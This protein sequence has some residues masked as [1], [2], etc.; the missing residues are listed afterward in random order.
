MSKVAAESRTEN[1][2]SN[3]LVFDTLAMS[4]RLRSVGVPEEQANEQ[5]EI[6]AEVFKHN[7]ATQADVQNIRKDITLIKREIADVRAELKK[8]IADVRKEIADLRKELKKD[9]ELLRLEFKKDMYKMKS[10]II[11]WVAG[12]LLAQAAVIGA[13]QKLF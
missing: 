2:K 4:K 5:V 7:M 6:I 11:L 8:D 10:S 9:I 3:G 1:N 13:M 12:M